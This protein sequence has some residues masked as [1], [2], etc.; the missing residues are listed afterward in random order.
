MVHPFASR[1]HSFA[2]RNNIDPNIEEKRYNTI[3]FFEP[4][5]HFFCIH[6]WLIFF[7]LL[8]FFRRELR[9]VLPSANFARNIRDG[10][11]PHDRALIGDNVQNQRGNWQERS[12]LFNNQANRGDN[13]SMN[14]EG[15][16]SQAN[17]DVDMQGDEK[18]KNQEQGAGDDE[19]KE[20]EE[21]P[22]AQRWNNVRQVLSKLN[23]FPSLAGNELYEHITQIKKESCQVKEQANNK[24]IAERTLAAKIMKEATG[25]YFIS[26]S[27][28]FFMCFILIKAEILPKKIFHP[29][30]LILVYPLRRYNFQL[31]TLNTF[32][33]S[34]LI[35]F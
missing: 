14:V 31:N 5:I 3:S 23:I 29:Q 1:V 30:R 32:F 6:D 27:N 24:I 22:E 15:S 18:D 20:E 21:N 13:D 25:I 33:K 9:N 10:Q 11:D 8:I 17:K 19:R 4:V 35:S 28:P 34:F 2:E 7:F 26:L 12:G 16:N